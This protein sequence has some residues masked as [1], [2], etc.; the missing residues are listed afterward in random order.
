MN[1]GASSRQG[2]LAGASSWHGEHAGPARIGDPPCG[3][4]SQGE[5]AQGACAP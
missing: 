3:A 1:A 4:G 2:E 5:L